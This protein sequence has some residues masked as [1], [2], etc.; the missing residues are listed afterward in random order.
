MKLCNK[1]FKMLISPPLKISLL[2]SLLSITSKFPFHFPAVICFLPSSS[3]TYSSSLYLPLPSFLQLPF[4]LFCWF[5]LFPLLFSFVLCSSISSLPLS[6][7]SLSLAHCLSLSFFLCFLQPAQCLIH[8]LLFVSSDSR[9]SACSGGRLFILS[10]HLAY[11][12]PAVKLLD[13]Y[14]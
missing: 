8:P 12:Q 5:D 13:N 3:L 10:L 6:F 9:F 4:P 1:T 11:L 7:L 2:L 14:R